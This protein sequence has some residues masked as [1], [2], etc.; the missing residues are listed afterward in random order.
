MDRYVMNLRKKK[1]KKC[2]TCAYALGYVKTL[3]CP[4]PKCTGK[5][6]IFKM[7]PVVSIGQCIEQMDHNEKEYVYGSELQFYGRNRNDGNRN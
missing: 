6:S 4:C 1:R 3:V 7:Y 2:K 5:T